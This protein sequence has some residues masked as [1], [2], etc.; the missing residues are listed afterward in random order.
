MENVFI[1]HL[2]DS[3]INTIKYSYASAKEAN[4][5]VWNVIHEKKMCTGNG[6]V[7]VCCEFVMAKNVLSE[8]GITN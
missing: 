2:F 5:N 7:V 3:K 4:N 1:V 6:I 8:I